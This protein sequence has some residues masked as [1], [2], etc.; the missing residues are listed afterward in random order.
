MRFNSVQTSDYSQAARAV[1]KNMDSIYNTSRTTAPDFNKIAEAALETRS[2]ER[3]AVAGLGTLSQAYVNKKLYDQEQAD[4]ATLKGERDALQQQQADFL[5]RIEESNK[6]IEEL[7]RKI[8]GKADDNLTSKTS[9][10]NGTSTTDS[11]GETSTQLD[12]PQ[13]GETPKKVATASPQISAPQTAVGLTMSTLSGDQEKVASRVRAVESGD[14]GYDAFNQFGDKG[15]HSNRGTGGAYGKKFGTPLTEMTLAQVMEKQKDHNNRSVSDAQWQ[16]QGGIWAAGAYQ[17]I[18]TT[19]AGVVSRGGFDT[20]RKFDAKLQDELFA[21]HVR[22][23]RSLQPWVGI[24]G[25]SDYGSL[26]SLAQSA[27]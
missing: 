8:L 5:K 17:F 12:A 14:W 4:R 26:N 3:R 7:Q 15:G 1:T 9:D 6:K 11:T 22:E 24:R 27:F 2:Q 20:S 23:T 21:F 10:A 25:A 19:L 13:S 18:P 16:K